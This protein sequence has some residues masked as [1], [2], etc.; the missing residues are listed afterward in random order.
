MPNGQIITNIPDGMHPNEI[1]ATLQRG[2]LDTKK[3]LQYPTKITDAPLKLAQS[4]VGSVRGIS[5]VFGANNPVSQGLAGLEAGIG[6]KTSKGQKQLEEQNAAT[7]AAAKGKGLGAETKAFLST[8]AHDPLGKAAELVGGIAPAIGAGVLTGG[9]ATEATIAARLAAAAPMAGVMAAQSIG[10]TKGAIYEKVKQALLDA[11]VAPE[12]AEEKAQKAQSYA[13]PNVDQIALS[14]ALGAIAGEVGLPA[15][16]AKALERKLVGEVIE[17]GAAKAA[18]ENA[19]KEIAG[20]VTKLTTETGPVARAAKGFAKDAAIMGG[21]SG[22]TKLAENIAMQRAGF[23]TP[24]FEGVA[25]EAVQQGIMGGALGAGFGVMHGRGHGPEPKPEPEVEQKP[26]SGI[27]EDIPA[28]VDPI[29]YAATLAE[30]QKQGMA[31]SL[32][33]DHAMFKASIPTEERIKE[34]GPNAPDIGE[35]HLRGTEPSV[36]RDSGLGGEPEAATDTG[37]ARDAGVEPVGGDLGAAPERAG[38]VDSPLKVEP[39]KAE[40]TTARQRVR[41]AFADPKVFAP[42]ATEFGFKKK[43]LPNDIRE[44]ATDLHVNDPLT[45]SPA[46]ALR[47]AFQDARAEAF[48]AEPIV[49]PETTTEPISPVSI[50]KE[51]IP[52]VEVAKEA[53]FPPIKT[54]P[55][56]V[57]EPVRAPEP[58]PV[59]EPVAALDPAAEPAPP[60]PTPAPVEE[61]GLNAN[62]IKV[63]EN[64]LDKALDKNDKTAIATLKKQGILDPKGKVIADSPFMQERE[65]FYAQREAEREAKSVAEGNPPNGTPIDK[66]YALE[67]GQFV[68][69][70]KEKFY[71]AL[72]KTEPALTREELQTRAI[73]GMDASFGENAQRG[74]TTDPITAPTAE[75]VA[76]EPVAAEPIVTA[77]KGKKGKKAEAPVE[78]PVEPPAI[79][80]D[81]VQKVIDDYRAKG[82][83]EDKIKT[84]ENRLK[85]TKPEAFI[86]TVRREGD[87]ALK[88]VER[89]TSLDRERAERTARAAEE[90]ERQQRELAEKREALRVAREA[91]EAEKK[92]AEE[93]KAKASAEKGPVDA[94][95]TTPDGDPI[96]A[97]SKRIEHDL[98][99]KSSLEVAGWL[100]TNAP[101]GFRKEVATRVAKLMRSLNE[102][103]VEFDFKINH[104]GDKSRAPRSRGYNLVPR[105]DYRKVSTRINGS[106]VTGY[107][108]TSYTWVLHEFIHAVTQGTL[109][110]GRYVKHA[111]TQAGK[112]YDK[113]TKLGNVVIAHIKER[114]DSGAELTPFEKQ[115]LGIEG[116]NNA[117]ADIHELVA[118]GL[119]DRK[120]QEWLDTI[121]YK[122]VVSVWK[123][124]VRTMGEFLGLAKKDDTALSELL[125][126]SEELLSMKKKDLAT[127]TEHTVK[128]KD[129]ATASKEVSE[130]IASAKTAD[131]ESSEALKTVERSLKMANSARSTDTATEGLSG[132]I[133]ARDPGKLIP[134]DFFTRVSTKQLQF[135]LP[136]L[137]TSMIVNYLKDRVPAIAAV[138]KLVSEWLAQRDSF[139]RRDGAIKER[140]KNFNDKYGQETLAKIQA[141]ARLHQVDPTAYPT[142]REAIRNDA[143]LRVLSDKL[144]DMNLSSTDRE[145]IGEELKTRLQQFK[146]VYDLWEQ[147]G[148]QRDGHALFKDINQYHRDKYDLMRA[149]LNGNLARQQMSDKARKAIMAEIRVSLETAKAESNPFKHIPADLLPDMYSPFKRDGDYYLR[150]KP[151]AGKFAGEFHRFDTLEQ[152]LNAKNAAARDLG[153]NPESREAFDWGVNADN[154]NPRINE[155]SAMLTRFF[156]VVDNNV[157]EGAKGLSTAQAKELKDQFY[158]VFLTS[159]P[160]QSL[161]KQFIHAKGVGGFSMDSLRTFESSSNMYNNQIS[162]MHF[163]PLIE[164][165]LSE[166]KDLIHQAP[167]GN[168][169]PFSPTEQLKMD[170]VYNEMALRVDGL[171]NPKK[172]SSLVNFL[173]R[174]AYMMYLTSGA[175]A[176]TQYTGIPIRVLPRLS[177]FY[178]GPAAVAAL[179]KY[180]NV[181]QSVGKWKTVDSQGNTVFQFPTVGGSQ[182]MN[183][184]LLKRAHTALDARGVFGTLTKEILGSGPKATPKTAV[185]K[186]LRKGLDTAYN[187]LT[188]MFNASEYVSREMS[189]MAAFELHYKKTGDF[190]ASIEAASRLTADALGTHNEWEV[191]RAAKANDLVTAAFQFKMYPAK[192][193][194]FFIENFAAATKGD[195]GAMGELIGVL[196]M[197]G[198]F[199]GLRGMPL[200]GL[201][202][203]GASAW[204]K[205][206]SQN[207]DQNQDVMKYNADYI[208]RNKFLPQHFGAMTFPGADGKEHSY[209]DALANGLLS[210]GSGLNFGSHTSFNGMWFRAPKE[211]RNWEE[212]AM[213]AVVSNIAGV[214][215]GTTFL[216]GIEDMANGEV[217]RGLEQM[218]PAGVSKPLT[219]YRLATEGAET[220]GGDKVVKAGDI[221]LVPLLGQVVG[222]QPMDVSEQQQRSSAV[223]N[224]KKHIDAERGKLL[225]EYN[226]HTLMADHLDPARARRAYQKMLEFNKRYPIPAFQISADTLMQSQRSYYQ[227]HMNTVNGVAMTRKNAPYLMPAVSG[228]YEEEE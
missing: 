43:A 29:V 152:L 95:E 137:P 176:A 134:S 44:A 163:K 174:G 204:L 66:A 31:P 223:T 41:T 181:L 105:E 216:S 117:L 220:R 54:E 125:R 35:P 158:Q 131:K 20:N 140:L 145:E 91:A 90:N 153:L 21:L 195:V 122:G 187:A 22:Q 142:L 191:P 192:Q 155:T 33:R 169:L 14:G 225:D 171:M 15:S 207:D 4:A 182:L 205:A 7:T 211:G 74:S 138:D 58:A 77:P 53:E 80:R 160:E 166:A 209:A 108:G 69:P 172:A 82:V 183:N 49:E 164:G 198:L 185:E 68:Y 36:P 213:N 103:G 42:L 110:V 2:G 135:W 188:G 40:V 203:A 97:V 37:G 168:E 133:K 124:F 93:A 227:K 84:F 186:G 32:A 28:G 194:Q 193:T 228:N 1:L 13:G 173:K 123:Q 25:S 24:T 167:E 154:L 116:N 121:P 147:L 34:T 151:E 149:V 226:K 201:A 71:Q 215:V 56:P 202:M 180:T 148:E 45:Y 19:T 87:E 156:E 112:I 102:M 3:L 30:A 206:N 139:Q 162:K 9:A 86:K 119:S 146:E 170:A 62:R 76:A 101:D 46:E 72:L 219:A 63:V 55:A 38:P 129:G 143:S 52:P 212:T 104:I 109:N 17:E 214:S 184:P 26:L 165:K 94:E 99:G 113:L 157:E 59:A 67:K 175:T 100:V 150:I 18:A 8:V 177:R 159:L 85:L 92:A 118:W 217:Q 189:A 60:A 222:F 199:H 178:G 130:A 89:Q 107:A 96:E 12:V 83:P 88:A 57:A 47:K 75:P 65:A 78:V 23:N 48:K 51:V 221:G 39:T 27:A 120:M 106:D 161:R 179:G 79:T 114:R 132:T 64:L 218:L 10:G 81:D 210:E 208:F 115:M 141:L 16:A 11:K 98:E 196:G 6:E 200:Y 111:D 136:K 144:T 190:N 197:G 5:N 73:K 224:Q 70:A 128:T 126:V 50:P 61:T 127:W